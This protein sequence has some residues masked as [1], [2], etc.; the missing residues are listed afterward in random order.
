MPA[1]KLTF[2]TIISDVAQ[3]LNITKKEVKT[4]ADEINN[5]VL[6]GLLSGKKVGI[7]NLGQIFVKIKP[8]SKEKKGRNPLTGQEIMVPAKPAK[9]VPK[10][11][12]SKTLKE[13]VKKAKV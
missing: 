8:A 2:N 12:F 4:I 7:G 9:A 6:E 11:S 13:E 10:F 3:K 1:E 5:A